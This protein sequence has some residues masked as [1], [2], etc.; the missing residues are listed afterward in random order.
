MILCLQFIDLSKIF[1]LC[2]F[3]TNG[4]NTELI[5]VSC[6]IWHSWAGK[7]ERK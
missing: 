4:P 3:P 5:I 6:A 1:W 7:G 2:K